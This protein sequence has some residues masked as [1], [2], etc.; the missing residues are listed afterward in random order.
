MPTIPTNVIHTCN[1]GF[2]VDYSSTEN[3]MGLG[4]KISSYKPKVEAHDTLNE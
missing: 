4:P 1:V 3:I 2:H